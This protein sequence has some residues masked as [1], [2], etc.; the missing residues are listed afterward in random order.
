MVI[1]FQHPILRDH[2]V[3]PR[4]PLGVTMSLKLKRQSSTYVLW[5]RCLLLKPHSFISCRGVNHTLTLDSEFSSLWFLDSH[6]GKWVKRRNSSSSSSS[7]GSSIERILQKVMKTLKKTSK[8]NK[9]RD[10]CYSTDDCMASL[11]IVSVY[12]RQEALISEPSA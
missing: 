10:R 2:N 12:R 9:K 1:I 5:V 8:K 11:L 6:C 7:S 3:V 4:F